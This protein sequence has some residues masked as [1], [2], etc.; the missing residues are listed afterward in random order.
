[1][2]GHSEQ[3]NG[4]KFMPDLKRLVSVSSDGCIFVWRLPPELTESMRGL[5][6]EMGRLPFEAINGEINRNHGSIWSKTYRIADPAPIS[7]EKALEEAVRSP[8]ERVAKPKIKEELE[9]QVHKE[10]PSIQ[11]EVQTDRKDELSDFNSTITGLPDWIQAKMG[12]DISSSRE[13]DHQ[14][15][16]PSGRWAV[17]NDSLKPWISGR[18]GPCVQGEPVD[19]DKPSGEETLS[20][21]DVED[22]VDQEENP[23]Y[24]AVS[25]T[26]PSVEPIDTEMEEGKTE[27]E[28]SLTSINP[29]VSL[30]SKYWSKSQLENISKMT[31][32]I[33][34]QQ[35]DLLNIKQ[36]KMQENLTQES[37]E[38]KESS[39]GTKEKE[40]ML[41]LPCIFPREISLT[42]GQQPNVASEEDFDDT[43]KEKKDD[44]LT[45]GIQERDEIS[46][47][48]E[49]LN[50][51]KE[52]LE[53]TRQNGR[54][55]MT[56]DS[57]IKKN[58]MVLQNLADLQREKLREEESC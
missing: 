26:D 13:S 18:K 39:S 56:L 43:S 10:S 58:T 15:Q 16:P 11:T 31:M 29:R 55:L 35:Q 42:S 22:N 20:V 40:I 21:E 9:P 7:L 3:I 12:R 44:T 17:N 28:E 51:L 46:L 19:Y 24:S 52:L 53:A 14:P 1:M 57:S 2:I 38:T 27:N 34:M 8:G 50:T 41:D 54:L 33:C 48:R 37:E 23:E 5:L 30:S 45:Q 4:V 32:Q 49:M 47:R 25:G 6:E 36:D